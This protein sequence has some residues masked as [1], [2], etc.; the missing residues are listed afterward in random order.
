MYEPAE[1][2]RYGTRN[3]AIEAYI[4]QRLE[5]QIDYYE[6]KSA[7]NKKLY[8]SL[9]IGAIVANAMIPVAAVFLPSATIPKLIITLLSAIAAMISS[10][11]ILFNA[12]DLWAKYRRNASRLQA[13]RHQY[14]T[15]SGL[16]AGMDD[17]Q[18]FLRL[19]ELS[20]QHLQEENSSWEIMTQAC[21]DK[22]PHNV[23]T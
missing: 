7:H 4:H 15:R 1:P 18:A 12:R 10:I 3:D 2:P 20:E 19:V 17:E 8:Y 5:D 16:F 22:E 6:K 23:S 14:F 9:S 21:R 13:F 11:L